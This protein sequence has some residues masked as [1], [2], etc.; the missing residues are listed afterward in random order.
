MKNKVG[1]ITVPI[2]DAP[3]PKTVQDQLANEIE[4]LTQHLK[5]CSLGASLTL[6]AAALAA[7]G[8]ST[9]LIQV[10]YRFAFNTLLD[11]A[12]PLNPHVGKE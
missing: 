7:R 11:E 8:V 6:G 9:P 1:P 10:A 12:I 2:L 3:K 4:M 5:T